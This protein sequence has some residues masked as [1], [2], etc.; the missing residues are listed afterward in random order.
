LTSVNIPCSIGDYAFLS[1]NN[2]INVTFSKGVSIGKGAFS[3]CRSVENIILPDGMTSIGEGAFSNCFNLK[4]IYLPISITDIGSNVFNQCNNM[5]TIFAKA[6]SKPDGWVNDW[7]PNNYHV[8]WG[9]LETRENGE[10]RYAVLADDS[11]HILSLSSTNTNPDI[12]IPLT[13]DGIDVT[14]FSYTVFNNNLL[15]TSVVISDN[16]K[17]IPKFAFSG[18][19]NLN[20][21]TF[22]PNSQLSSIGPQAFAS[23]L[24]LKSITIPDSVT[25][26]GW[27]VFYFCPYLENVTLSNQLTSLEDEVFIGCNRLKNITIPDSITSIGDRVFKYCET[28]ATIVIPTSVT[29]IGN[30]AFMG[31]NLLNIN[32]RA[33]TQPS[34]WSSSWNPNN[35]PV[36]WG[37]IY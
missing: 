18:C 20:A 30:E 31:C 2:L 35:R 9:Y 15:L 22:G 8:L 34:G 23:C 37:Y 33:Y 1:C 4:S 6:I 28:M 5:L 36:H 24:A 16:I 21:V 10:F 3:Y 14:G 26:I 17:Q 25:I 11:I 32:C 12:I 13:I 27:G 19:D 29:T 7:N